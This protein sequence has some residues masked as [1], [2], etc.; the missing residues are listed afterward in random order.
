[1]HRNYKKRVTKS[2]RYMSK[3]AFVDC[4][5]IP[6]TGE[7]TQIKLKPQING[8][9]KRGVNILIKYNGN[10][11]TAIQKR[12]HNERAVSPSA[13]FKRLEK[14]L[15]GLVDNRNP[16]DKLVMI[17]HHSA[18]DGEVLRE[19]FVKNGSRYFGSYFYQQ[20]ICTIQ[21]AT[22]YLTLTNNMNQVTSFKLGDLC[23]YFNIEVDDSKL[24]EAEYDV[25]LLIKLYKKIENEL[26][27][28]RPTSN[29]GNNS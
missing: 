27:K 13:A 24:H 29:T 8:K 20:H 23:R 16:N 11:G 21:M 12:T 15:M 3:I 5:Y 26:R 25:E 7:I 1:M 28:L 18:A 10:K 9:M 17:A 14:Y 6:S 4:E 2:K 22:L 19:F